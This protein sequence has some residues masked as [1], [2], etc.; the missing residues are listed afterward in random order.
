M[1]CISGF[2]KQK[3]L[4]VKRFEGLIYGLLILLNTYVVSAI[5]SIIKPFVVLEYLVELY[6]CLGLTLIVL[7]AIA[8]R[9]WL[10]GDSKSKF[11]AFIVLFL[12]CSE[13]INVIA[14]YLNYK[15]LH[16]LGVLFFVFGLAFCV[17]FS[18]LENKNDKV[19]KLVK[20]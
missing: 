5:I 18:V 11:F 19:F 3:S 14:I 9:Y 6:F 17:M 12:T 7:G 13:I 1:L 16:Y 2:T 10:I 20:S 4:G 8:V 15:F